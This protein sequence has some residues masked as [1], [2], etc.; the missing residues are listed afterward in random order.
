M[1]FAAFYF[2][3]YIFIAAILMMNVVVAIILEQYL[4]TTAEFNKEDDDD[5][6]TASPSAHNLMKTCK[7]NIALYTKVLSFK[8]VKEDDTMSMHFRRKLKDEVRQRES[9]ETAFLE[10]LRGRLNRVSS[11]T[12]N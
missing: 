3:S 10:Q 11:W 6:N 5:D 7:E 8:D 4:E 12:D 2:I 1:P 9:L